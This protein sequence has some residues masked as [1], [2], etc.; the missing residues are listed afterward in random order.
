M[1]SIAARAES[2]LNLPLL[3]Q[4]QQ[5]QSRDAQVYRSTMKACWFNQLA[6]QL[7]PTSYTSMVCAAHV[8]AQQY[9]KGCYGDSDTSDLHHVCKQGPQNPVEMSPLQCLRSADFWMLFAINGICSGAG[10]T[11]LNNVGQQVGAA[12]WCGDC[13]YFAVLFTLLCT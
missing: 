12:W 8:Y 11:L 10:L 4:Q 6:M 5:Q 2:D 1:P 3:E 7:R 13:Q 9:V